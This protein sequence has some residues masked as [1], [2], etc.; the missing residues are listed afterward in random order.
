MNILQN[1]RNILQDEK[2]CIVRFVFPV[3]ES[4]SFAPNENLK[5]PTL[6]EI[7][8]YQGENYSSK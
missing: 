3:R 6:S 7:L 2:A 8:K 4:F 5:V 1:L